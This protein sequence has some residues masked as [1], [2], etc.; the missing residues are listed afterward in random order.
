M[1]PLDVV[2][3]IYNAANHLHVTD[4]VAVAVDGVLDHTA[5]HCKISNF[6]RLISVHDCIGQTAGERIATAYPIQNGKGE[7]LAFPGFALIPHTGFQ[8]V[9][10]AAVGVPNMAGNAL[11]V[12]VAGGKRLEYP[13]LLLQR[14][15]QGDP[16][17][18]VAFFVILLVLSQVV[19][20]NAQQHIHIGK[21]AGA[22]VPCF[23]SG[24]QGAAE[25][26]VKAHGHPLFLRH[27]QAD[28]DQI[29]AVFAQRRGDAAQVQ[30]VMP[31]QQTLHVQTAVIIFHKR[32]VLAVVN[33]LTGTNAKAGFQKI[34][35]QTMAGGAAPE[36]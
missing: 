27:L 34:N 14:G 20:F 3:L 9:F 8:A 17:L 33:H 25:V 29:R 15:L 24:P 26:A 4:D 13:R 32:T 6:L 21:A 2:I 35:T 1:L 12:G 31:I 22:E 18:P 16:V 5:G 10:A 30:P 28:K 36:C 19:G 11:Q 7:Q 23:L